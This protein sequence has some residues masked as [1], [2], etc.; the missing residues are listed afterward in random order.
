MPDT[1][2]SPRP[3]LIVD[4]RNAKLVDPDGNCVGWDGDVVGYPTPN[5]NFSTLS[6]GKMIWAAA[7]NDTRRLPGRGDLSQRYAIH[8]PLQGCL[9]GCDF[10]ALLPSGVGIAA[11]LNDYSQ[12]GAGG[13][14]YALPTPRLEIW[15]NN[16][17]FIV[18]V[19]EDWYVDPVLGAF[20]NWFWVYAESTGAV[21]WTQAV[22]PPT[23]VGYPALAL[24]TAIRGRTVHSYI[25]GGAPGQDYQLRWI[26]TDTLGNLWRRTGLLLVAETS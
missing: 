4:Q 21:A 23:K 11:G 1:V 18:P 2:L 6:R 10:S 12:T 25:S 15:T 14:G 26:I 22:A 7:N 19:P 17:G 3:E 13:V 20:A 5:G 9:Y 24:G 16:P 8:S